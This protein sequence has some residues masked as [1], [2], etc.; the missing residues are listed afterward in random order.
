MPKIWV[1]FES[2]DRKSDV[3][4]AMPICCRGMA[5]LL[6]DGWSGEIHTPI[7]ISNG[8]VTA[9]SGWISEEISFCPMCGK[10]IN[11]SWLAPNV[12][13]LYGDAGNPPLSEER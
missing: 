13:R 3:Y 2:P 7:W 11:W 10:K 5:N 12:Q 9:H 6:G 4:K 1:E 8:K